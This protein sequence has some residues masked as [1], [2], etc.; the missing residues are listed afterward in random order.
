MD[1]V[2]AAYYVT[3]LKKNIKKIA[4]INQNYAWGQDSWNDF[5]AAMKALIPGVQVV[6]S[7]MPK[8]MA[9][10]YGAEISSLLSSNAD[11]IHSSFWG[12]DLEAF[13]LQAAPRGLFKKSTVILTAGESAMYRLAKQ[14]PGWDNPRRLADLTVFSHR[15][16]N[17][18][19]GSAR[20]IRN[21]MPCLPL[22]LPIKWSRPS[23][24]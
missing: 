2:A 15:I 20:P 4:G 8:F 23:W 9:G 19:A 13:V 22:I 6:V 5:E 14:T 17:S 7:Q 3:E 18:I 12:G 1:N 11:V 21:V 16:M 24:G 10:Q